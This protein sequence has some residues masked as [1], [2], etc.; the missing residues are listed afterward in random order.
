MAMLVY[1]RVF[2]MIKGSWEAIFRVADDWNSNNKTRAA[3]IRVMTWGSDDSG[4]R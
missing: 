1:Q 2:F 4:K 3:T